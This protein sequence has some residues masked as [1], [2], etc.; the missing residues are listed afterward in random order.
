MKKVHLIYIAFFAIALS[1]KEHLKTTKVEKKAATIDSI[2]VKKT[3]V[4]LGF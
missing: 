3:L 2:T 1:C 4:Y